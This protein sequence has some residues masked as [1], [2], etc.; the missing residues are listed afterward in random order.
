MDRPSSAGPAAEYAKALSAAVADGFRSRSGTQSEIA[1]AAVISPATL[2]RYLSG[3]RLA[4]REFLTELEKFFS[5]RGT[6]MPAEVLAQL[7]DL[8]TQA[9]KV[10][11]SPA[12][13]VRHLREDSVRREEDLVRSEEDLAQVKKD[14]ADEKQVAEQTLNELN[15]KIQDLA[16]QLGAA[17]E[18]ARTAERGQSELQDGVEEQN[19]HL[20]GAQ[21]YV[22]QVEAE[23][24]EQRD[25]VVLLQREVKTLRRQNRQLIEESTER[26]KDL[27]S[28][29]VSSM[30]TQVKGR[31]SGREGTRREVSGKASRTSSAPSKRS[32]PHHTLPEPSGSMPRPSWKSVAVALILGGAY[33]FWIIKDGNFNEY[34]PSPMR[35]A[36]QEIWD[37][38]TK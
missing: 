27:S 2:S 3:V 36:T 28:E 6:P 23:L 10:S 13:Q 15:A 17:W 30:S 1:K 8:C 12:I 37:L 34:G 4:P 25:K 19:K 11:R 14:L 31:Q 5:G 35:W 20:T 22:R 24:T 16:E 7:N 38:I 32:T 26:T 29:S 18:Q 33:L 21:I 9:H